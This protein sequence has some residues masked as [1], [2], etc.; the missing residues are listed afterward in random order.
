MAFP[1]FILYIWGLFTVYLY[2]SVACVHWV[3]PPSAMRVDLCFSLLDFLWMFDRTSISE[4]ESEEKH[5]VWDPV[6]ELTIN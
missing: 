4:A 6:P 3:L 5:G 2:V 1:F